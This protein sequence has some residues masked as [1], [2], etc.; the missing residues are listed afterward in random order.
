MTDTKENL[1]CPACG[2][3]MKKVFVPSAGVNVDLCLEGC[4]GVFFDNRELDKFDEQTDDISAIN[5]VLHG[6]DFEIVDKNKTRVCPVCH[7]PMVKIGAR[8]GVEIDSCNVC[9][10]KFLDYGELEQ[11]RSLCSS[12]E[13]KPQEV[14]TSLFKNFDEKYSSKQRQLIEEVIKSY[15]E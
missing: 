5:G 6:R 11:I 9:G 12:K 13:E 2:H 4:G 3:S 7:V 8:S 14:L 10:G 15:L 1:T